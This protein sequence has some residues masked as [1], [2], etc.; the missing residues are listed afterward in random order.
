MRNQ[1]SGRLPHVKGGVLPTGG[2]Y[3]GGNKGWREVH[4]PPL[5]LTTES[6]N[7]GFWVLHYSYL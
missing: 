4:C 2:Q 6:Q 5:L 7:Q 3:N 1:R